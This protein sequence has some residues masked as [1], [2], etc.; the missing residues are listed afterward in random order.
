MPAFED[1]VERVKLGTSI[2]VS[3]FHVIT[4]SEPA[5]TLS[6]FR[7]REYQCIE[8]MSN[9]TF[10]AREVHAILMQNSNVGI[11]SAIVTASLTPRGSR[12]VDI[13]GRTV[14]TVLLK[15]YPQRFN[16]HERRRS[17]LGK[18]IGTHSPSG[19]SLPAR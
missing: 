15:S 5:R 10:S 17:G 6:R 7:P 9:S 16:L 12:C 2:V 3:A 13:H 14:D 8:T 11:T 1:S 4:W 18:C 19:L